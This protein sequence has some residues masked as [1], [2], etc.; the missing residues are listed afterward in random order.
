[1]ARRGKPDPKVDALREAR[2][3]NPRP[4]QVRDEEFTSS[5]FFDARD[6]VQVKYEM[7]RRVRVGGASVTA[8]AAAF[9]FSRPSYYEAAAAL[10]RAGLPALVPAKPGPRAA[11]KLTDEVIDHAQALLDADSS[12]RAADLVEPLRVRFGV[13]VHPRSIERALA[14][15][16]QAASDRKSG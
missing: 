5:G 1:V 10:Q 2:T 6:L 7:V 11:H 9:G 15:R 8:A 3:L 12:L 13:A 14:R 4:Q 16:Q